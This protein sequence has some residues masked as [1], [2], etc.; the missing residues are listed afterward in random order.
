MDRRIIYGRLDGGVS[1][2]IPARCIDDGN[3]TDEEIFQRSWNKL[4]DDAINPQPITIA[5]IPPDRIFRNAWEHGGDKVNVNMNSAREIHLGRIRM[6]RDKALALL[7]VETIKAAGKG[8]SEALAAVEAQK[9]V[10]RD[11]PQ[12]I[13]LTKARTPE[14]LKAIWPAEVPRG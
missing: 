1:V 6:A 3:L 8:D 2:V 10:L 5:D 13:D 11:I 9:Q 12:T 7:D 14:E 4:P